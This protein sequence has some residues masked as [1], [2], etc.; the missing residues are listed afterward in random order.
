MSHTHRAVM[1]LSALALTACGG[2]GGGGGA[3]PAGGSS[4]VATPAPT[5]TTPAASAASGADPVVPPADAASSGSVACTAGDAPQARAAAFSLINVTREALGLP[6]LTRASAVDAVAQAHAQYAVANGTTGSD[7]VQGKPCYTGATLAQRLA[8][9]GV[10]D[11]EAPGRRS[12]S[13]FLLSYTV[14]G[15]DAQPWDYVTDT[16]SALYGRMALLDPR[17]QQ[18]GVGFSSVSGQRAM[19]LDTALQSGAV[20]AG[21]D[22]WVVWPRDGASG[23]ATRLRTADLRPLAQVT[24]GYPVTLHAAAAVQVSRFVLSTAS[25]GAAVAA[26]VVTR[27]ND[28]NGFLAEGEAALLPLAALK[29]GTAYRAEFD[30]S[31]GST[32]VHLAWSFT[33]AP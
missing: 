3:S 1:L 30:G 2:G 32:P 7:E 14:A 33:T 20:N 22:T 28:R 12:R 31:V 5:P 15:A 17:L 25:D 27:A 11:V 9:A 4:V 24:E 16:L 19:V 10:V 8:G 13:E 23:L 21:S 6:A 29:P 26:A 18:V